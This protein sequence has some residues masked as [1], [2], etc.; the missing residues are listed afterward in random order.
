MLLLRS[1][2]HQPR[3]A[4]A[5]DSVASWAP[6]GCDAAADSGPDVHAQ[7]TCQ[8]QRCLWTQSK[9]FNVDVRGPRLLYSS[10][11]AYAN[12]FV[13]NSCVTMFMSFWHF[14]VY[15]RCRRVSTCSRWARR[16][17]AI[18]KPW[19][20]LKLLVWSLIIIFTCKSQCIRS[21]MI[22]NNKG[23]SGTENLLLVW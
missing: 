8:Y 13:N 2:I 15:L 19:S 7:V 16:A 17:S 21:E 12:A 22:R 18:I 10:A 20:I 6:F 3:A 5:D 9:R 23:W 4:D 1:L 11:R 14:I